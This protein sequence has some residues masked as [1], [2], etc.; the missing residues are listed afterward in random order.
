MYD[1]DPN[2]AANY[3]QKK[4]AA[5]AR[6]NKLPEAAGTFDAL[7]KT[8]RKTRTP[9][10]G[11]VYEF[12]FEVTKSNSESVCVG[13]QYT[14]AFF[15]GNGD[16]DQAMFWETITPLLMAV[17]GETNIVTFNSLEQLGTLTGA[18]KPDPKTPNV[19]PEPLDL[20]FRIVRALEPCKPNKDGVIKHKNPDGSAKIFPRDTFVVAAA[21]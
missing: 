17:T 15:P 16:V 1:I 6:G 11:D 10:A 12:K 21:A 19:Q 13:A 5:G 2:L 18:C 9:R 3:D 14:L 4:V 20:G 8:V 7:L